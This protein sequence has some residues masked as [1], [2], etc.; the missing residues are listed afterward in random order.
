MPSTW[1]KYRQRQIKRVKMGNQASLAN[2]YHQ[3]QLPAPP[4]AAAANG[5]SEP[6]ESYLKE[7]QRDEHLKNLGFKRSK[8][9]RKSISKRLKRKRNRH[10]QQNDATDGGG[11]GKV[12]TEDGDGENRVPESK[13][14][15]GTQRTSEPSKDRVPS[16]ERLD[17]PEREKPV[18]GEPQPMPGQMMVRIERS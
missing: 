17:A 3:A 8:S 18:V 10:Q 9:L 5:A 11:G 14:D 15:G 13:A 7:K 4:G 16:I 2:S 12:E 1:K 6:L